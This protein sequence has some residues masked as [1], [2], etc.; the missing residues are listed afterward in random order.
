MH[1]SSLGTAL[2]P[3]PRS[4]PPPLTWA[5]RPRLHVTRIPDP[6]AAPPAVPGR[7][8]PTPQARTAPEPGSA[9]TLGIR[10]LRPAA[11]LPPGRG[12]PRAQPGRTRRPRRQP[13]P[14]VPTTGAALTATPGLWLLRPPAH[15]GPAAPRSI[16]APRRLLGTLAQPPRPH[17][18]GA[19]VRRPVRRCAASSR[20]RPR[21]QLQ[22]RSPAPAHQRLL[23]EP[24][25]TRSLGWRS[26]HMQGGRRPLA[27]GRWRVRGRAYRIPAAEGGAGD[28]GRSRVTTGHSSEQPPTGPSRCRR[29]AGA[30]AVGRGSGVVLRRQE[31]NRP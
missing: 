15:A 24:P 6:T 4:L 26:L 22:R 28:P 2:R 7:F 9:A 16:H 23:S 19:T 30:G 14:A 29:G 11:T 31:G 12:R 21:R 17:C 13:A 18:E 5:V 20:P 25:G 1:P 27:R 8:S 10:G 3:P